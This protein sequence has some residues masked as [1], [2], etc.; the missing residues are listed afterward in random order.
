MKVRFAAFVGF[1]LLVGC[2]ASSGAGVSSAGASAGAAPS[3]TRGGAGGADAP[4][5][6]LIAGMTG[7]GG[8]PVI[9]GPWHLPA[10]FTKTEFGGYQLGAPLSADAVAQGG[11][12]GAGPSDSCGSTIL[13]VVRD[14][15]GKLDPNPHPDF[16]AYSGATPTLGMVEP[17]LGSD[18]KPVYTG[19][20][21]VAAHTGAC[22]NGDQTTSRAA[23]DQWYRYDATVNRPYVVYFALQPNGAK[24]TFESHAFFPLDGAGWTN[25]GRTHNYHF[26][27][28]V[29][30][31][32]K[33]VGGE[34]F[35]FIGDD[36]VWVFINGNLAV[37]LGGLHIEATGAVDLDAA[38]DRFG[39]IKGNVYTL[40]LFHA[41]RHTSASNFKIDTDLLFTNCGTIVP[42]PPL[43]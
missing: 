41:E 16:E 25:Q 39:I 8:A 33:Y 10:G 5:T 38:A 20:C 30:T 42:E 4:S 23:F 31:R 13:G 7:G 28:E 21:E 14:F 34:R 24:S 12:G 32:F 29:H 26:T 37:D 9:E 40:D 18:D 3:L 19:I 22:P 17:K 35:S 11:A 15:N 2:S 6:S 1:E 43:H 36:D 27:T